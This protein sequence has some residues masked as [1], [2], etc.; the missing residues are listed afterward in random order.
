MIYS[1]KHRQSVLEY[2]L[3]LLPEAV[4][5]L[6]VLWIIL[7]GNLI[8]SDMGLVQLALAGAIS[9]LVGAVVHE[10]SH[11]V[12]GILAGRDVRRILIGSGRTLFTFRVVNTR[13]QVCAY[14]LDGG[15]VTFSSL[16]QPSRGGLIT[17]IAAG[18]AANL[19]MGV[20]ALPAYQGAGWVGVFALLNILLGITN[21]IPARFSA[22]GQD[23]LTDGM[24][25]LRLLRGRTMN[26]AYFEGDESA[27]DAKAANIGAL[28]EARDA[29][30]EDITEVH[31]L[32]ALNRDPEIRRV[33]SPA[34]V[35]DIVRTA[36][37]ESSDAIRPVRTA[38]ADA[39]EKT[40]FHVARDAGVSQ[41]NAAHI[42]LAMMTVPSAVATRLKEAGVSEAALREIAAARARSAEAAEPGASTVADL[43]L[44]RWGTAADRPLELAFRIAVADHAE[45]TG[46]QH[47]VV[48]IL[49]QRTSRAGLALDRLGF[50]VT[51]NAKAVP[52]RD[53]PARTPPLSPQAQTA[54]AG[55]LLRTGPTYAAGSGELCLGVADQGRGMGGLL[56]LEADVTSEKLITALRA[57]P[58]EQSDPVGYTPS[59]RRM[60]ELRASA[61]LGAGRYAD[62][63]ADF[64]VLESHAPNEEALAISRNNV[65][66]AALLTG[67]PTLRAEA[68]EKSAAALAFKPDQRAFQGTHAFAQL[69]TGSVTEAAEALEKVV[70]EHPRPRDR[71]LDLCLLAI[72]RA[73]LG[74][75]EAAR[76]RLDEAE[77]IDPRCTLLGRGRR[78]VESSTASSAPASAPA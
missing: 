19:V 70:V 33:L 8:P 35:Q 73:R 26:A 39:I 60:W 2:L 57:L 54:I 30:S 29:G 74:D 63:L 9:L 56:F 42:A 52:Q 53:P 13:V 45:D 15:S 14:L 64:R 18:P 72:C 24:Q 10:L 50:V 66:W 22:G 43:P 62:S 25:I 7:F 58:R 23:S 76:R 27:P 20:V 51:R 65:A 12:V 38:T 71:A 31:I 37:P 6:A 77:G 49:D 1:A 75:H 59:M 61:R 28:E 47:I 21:L 68:L 41:P 55:A 36:G 5:F 32:A 3:N 40:A 11:F 4:V 46:T 17:A 69:E 78:E 44:E 16:D 34:R 67:D 48:A